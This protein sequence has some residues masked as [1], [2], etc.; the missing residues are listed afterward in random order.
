MQMRI[1][2]ICICRTLP[3]QSGSGLKTNHTVIQTLSL[4]T[5]CDLALRRILNTAMI[6]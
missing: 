2:I 1:L 5:P 4:I 3:F 6:P